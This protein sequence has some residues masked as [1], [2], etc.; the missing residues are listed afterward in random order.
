VLVSKKYARF[1]ITIRPNNFFFSYQ[2]KI[3]NS[4]NRV[5]NSE[6]L[7]IKV[8]KKRVKH[9]IFTFLNKVFPMFLSENFQEISFVILELNTPIQLRH[10]LIKFIEKR[11]FLKKIKRKILVLSYKN[12]K[13]YNGCR[14]IKPKRV[15]R[16]SKHIN[17]K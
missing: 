13:S 6:M 12:T 8:T 11:G 17:Y 9:S 15:K 1:S 16:K 4:K 3:D 14:A 7:K 2:N 10:K 5:I